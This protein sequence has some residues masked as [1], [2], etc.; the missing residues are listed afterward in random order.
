MKAKGLRF[1]LLETQD[2]T[3]FCTE[4]ISGKLKGMILEVTPIILIL[5]FK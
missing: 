3:I 1:I 4:R 5:C 2:I